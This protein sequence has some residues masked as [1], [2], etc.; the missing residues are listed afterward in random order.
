MANDGEDDGDGDGDDDDDDFVSIEPPR[1]LAKLDYAKKPVAK[2]DLDWNNNSYSQGSSMEEEDH[3]HYNHFDHHRQETVVGSINEDSN[4]FALE[5][6]PLIES[7]GSAAATT[8][9]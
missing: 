1:H 3:Y 6:F 4:G 5:N 8:R 2:R 9:A 7:N